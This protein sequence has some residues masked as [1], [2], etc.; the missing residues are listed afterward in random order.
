ME[1]PAVGGERWLARDHPANE[2]V[3]GVDE[4]HAEDEKSRG[5]LGGA[6][7]RQHR[8]HRAEEGDAGRSEEEL[9][10]MEVEE[11]EPRDRAREREGHPRDERLR[12]LRQERQT[13]KRERGD[14][15]DARRKTVKP[16]DEVERDVHADDPEHRE[17]D[18]DRERELDQAIGKRVV[19]EVD[20]DPREDDDRSDDEETEELPARAKLEHVVD[21]ADAHTEERRD[22]RQREPRGPDLLRDEEGMSG[23]AVDEPEGEDRRAERDRDGESAGPRDRSWMDAPT[24]WCVEHAEASRE[25]TYDRRRRGGQRE[26]E[27]C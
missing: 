12:D 20:V 17:R 25:Q 4:R 10:G 24:A 27:Q 19:H 26:P 3:E 13:A 11:E 5:D 23:Q 14:G 2:D 7:D 16:V 15:S 22:G 8:E 18:G 1:V 6:E 21:Q 9:R